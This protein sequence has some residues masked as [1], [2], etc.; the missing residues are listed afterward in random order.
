MPEHERA[1]VLLWSSKMLDRTRGERGL[2][3]NLRRLQLVTQALEDYFA[4]RGLWFRGPKESVAWLLQHDAASHEAFERAARRCP[5]D[6]DLAEVVR[7]VYG[8]FRT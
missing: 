1:A 5:S 2:E 3:A 4:L 7:M 6:D 8:P